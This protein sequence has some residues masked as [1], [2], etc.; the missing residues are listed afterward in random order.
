MKKDQKVK[1]LKGNDFNQK[2]KN[3]LES[4]FFGSNKKNRKKFN[5]I[6]KLF[7]ERDKSFN[8]KQICLMSFIF[9]INQYYYEDI[10]SSKNHFPEV[11][12][13]YFEDKHEELNCD[14]LSEQDYDIKDYG[15]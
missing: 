15:N 13:D 8:F 6:R 2:F 3:V 9:M 4:E 5:Q 1:I 14:E 10:P 7:N 11:Y 12:N